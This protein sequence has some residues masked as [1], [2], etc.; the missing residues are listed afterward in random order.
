MKIRSTSAERGVAPRRRSLVWRVGA[1][2]AT[3]TG[4]LLL[5]THIWVWLLEG[6]EDGWAPRTRELLERGAHTGKLFVSDI[7][8]WEVAVKAAKAQL[9]LSTP[10]ATWFTRAQTAPGI[11]YLP[12][13]RATLV[14][15][16]QLGAPMHE[17]PADRMLVATAQLGSVSLVTVDEKIL[18]YALAHRG[19]PA[20]DARR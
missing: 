9:E 20:C 17:D 14:H 1:R 3:H 8:F 4:P 7:S 5:D 18:A 13:D 12:V 10:V 15:S 16:T 6:R 19:T 11:Q 2:A